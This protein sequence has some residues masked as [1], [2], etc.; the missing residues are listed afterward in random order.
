MFLSDLE[1]V[2]KAT[3]SLGHGDNTLLKQ[4]SQASNESFKSGILWCIRSWKKT[5]VYKG[6]VSVW[7]RE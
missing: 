6:G 7:Y 4:L 1:K 5:Q 2:T 3:A